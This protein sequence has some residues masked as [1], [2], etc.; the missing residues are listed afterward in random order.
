[1]SVEKFQEILKQPVEADA[2]KQLHQPERH[3]LV[4]YKLFAYLLARIEALE[5]RLSEPRC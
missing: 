5:A 4:S 2:V 1:M 3:V